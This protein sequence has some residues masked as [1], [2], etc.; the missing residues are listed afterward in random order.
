MDVAQMGYRATKKSRKWHFPF[1]DLKKAFDTVNHEI[2]LS[3][4]D[5]YGLADQPKNGYEAT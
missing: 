5:K 4:C 1:L 3:K 2:L